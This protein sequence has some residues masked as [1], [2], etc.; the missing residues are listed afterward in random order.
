MQILRVFNNNVVLA[1][2]GEGEVVVTGRGVGFGARRGDVVD[3]AKVARVFV[4]SD[5]RD[6]D[7]S[8]EM[9]AHLPEHRIAQVTAALEAV[10]APEQ[11]RDKLTLITAIADHL[12][13][14]SWRA[15]TG[16]EATYLLRSEVSNLYPREWDLS[17]RLLAEVNRRQPA[18]AQLPDAET[19]ALALHLVNAGFATGDL[20]DTYRMTGIIQQMLEVVEAELGEALDMASISVARFITHVRY[21]F[22]RLTRNQQLDHAHSPLTRQ[23]V[24]AYPREIAC[25]RKIAAVVELRFD[26]ALTEDE[27][28]YLGLHIVRLG[29]TER[30]K[31]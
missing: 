7:H 18:D 16:E 15:R 9:L 25:A 19:T 22:V 10:G 26:T 24:D 13:Y 14:A 11:L 21:L 3:D 31:K 17:V 8:A 5:G 23:L 4:P 30:K 29:E 6:P 2:G 27:I 28:L 12:E 20:S 1:R